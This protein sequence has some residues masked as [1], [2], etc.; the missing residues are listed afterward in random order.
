MKRTLI[1]LLVAA[2]AVTILGGCHPYAAD[3]PWGAARE[4]VEFH[5]LGVYETG[6][7]LHRFVDRHILDH[8]LRDPDSYD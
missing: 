3:D 7:T 1:H 5:V 6:D 8:N 4:H 2:G